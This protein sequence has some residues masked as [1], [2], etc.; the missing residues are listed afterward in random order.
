MTAQIRRA[1]DED[2]DALVGLQR[3][4]HQ[5]HVANRPDF[6]T[7]TRDDAVAGWLRGLLASEDARIWVAIDAGIVVGNV[8]TN[9]QQRPKSIF[10]SALDWCEVD[11]IVV[12]QAHRRRGIAR[13]LLNAVI[14]DAHAR[15]IADIQLTS[16]SFNHAAHAAFERLGF[17][18]KLTRFELKR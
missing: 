11:Q 2:V 6:F 8:L 1:T 3:E 10:S 5:L 13:A 15:G 9:Q 7:P 4:I 12:A 16:W 17:A 18:P 14:D